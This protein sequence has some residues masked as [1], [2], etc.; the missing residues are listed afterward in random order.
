[1]CMWRSPVIL[2]LFHHLQLSLIT[3]ATCCNDVPLTLACVIFNI[4]QLQCQLHL[5]THACAGIII[6]ACITLVSG[7]CAIVKR[8]VVCQCAELLYAACTAC[9][10]CTASTA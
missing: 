1:M 5:G 8:S 10:A 3:Y 9:T 4:S 7:V 2:Q 6:T